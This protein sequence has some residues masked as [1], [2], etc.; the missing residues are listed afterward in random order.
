MRPWLLLP[1]KLA[2]DL[3]PLALEFNW[4]F[5]ERKTY[6]W[7][8]F[9]WRGISFQN[10]LGIAGGV[11]K[12]ASQVEEWWMYGPGFI[13]IGTVT[14][15][16]QGPNPGK[17]ISRDNKLEAVWNRMGFPSDGAWST[18]ENLRDLQ[19]P[20][21]SPVFVNIG[22][23]RNTPNEEAARDYA[24]C[25]EILAGYADAFVVN[26][27][28]PNTKGLRELL[29][30][31]NLRRFLS[32]VLAAR[33]KCSAP[34]TPVLLKISPDLTDHDL[35]AI[36]E[37][38]KD[39]GVD[40]FIATNTTLAR[41]TGSPF[42]AEGGVSGKPLA[43]RSKAVLKTLVTI[44]GQSR[45]DTLI[46]S[47]G[48]VMSPQDVFERLDMGADLVQVYSALIFHGPRF[49]RSVAEYSQGLVHT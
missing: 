37:T 10:R 21:H 26:I 35:F 31:A 7:R 19:R 9:S 17:I 14:P 45:G 36:V 48:G 20:F 24:E 5:G 16:P 29:E 40:G 28:S 32:E 1:A 13:E 38:A 33:K 49:F 34:Q 43:A 22:K 12:N 47:A 46:V 18:Q 15:K 8:P 6:T 44:L 39:L 25:M 4:L 42:P 2:H 41:E 30:P 27:S 11:D 23:N 3:A